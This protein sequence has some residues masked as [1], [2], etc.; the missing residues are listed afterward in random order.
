MNNCINQIRTCDILLSIL[1]CLVFSHK[2][3]FVR[4]SAD[5]PTSEVDVDRRSGALAV[6]SRN[7]N[8]R[9]CFGRDS[10]QDC[11]A[12][13]LNSNLEVSVCV[14]ICIWRIFV[15]RHLFPHCIAI[16]VQSNSFSAK[17]VGPSKH[18]NIKRSLHLEELLYLSA[19]EE[20]EA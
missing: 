5:V 12:P 8:N 16:L 3:K 11:L 10:E 4:Q 2:E 1:L 6:A 15:Y 18:G 19:T 9:Q 17:S 14:R 7:S 13:M 20:L